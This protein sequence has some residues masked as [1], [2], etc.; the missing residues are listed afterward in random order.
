[1][2][3]QRHGDGASY[4]NLI[5]AFECAG[6]KVL[7]DTV[8]KLGSKCWSYDKCLIIVLYGRL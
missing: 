8:C 6:H 4:K 3:K 5:G 2:W 1:M 7:A